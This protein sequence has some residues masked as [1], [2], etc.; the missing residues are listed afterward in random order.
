MNDWSTIW[1]F[2]QSP[3]F[4]TSSTRPTICQAFFQIVSRSRAAYSALV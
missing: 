2:F 4:G 1:Y 3:G